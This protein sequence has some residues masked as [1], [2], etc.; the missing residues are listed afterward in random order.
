VAAAVVRTTATGACLTAA[1]AAAAAEAAEEEDT[2]A[3]FNPAPLPDTNLCLYFLFTA[4][5][6]IAKEIIG[7]PITFLSEFFLLL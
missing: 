5:A 2:A 3:G 6:L 1:T 4:H 7:L